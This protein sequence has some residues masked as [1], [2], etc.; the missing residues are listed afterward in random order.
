MRRFIVRLLNV[1]RGERAEEE[2]S[3]ELTSHLALLEDEHVRRGLSPE[4][5]RQA[6]RRA[7][8]SVALTQERHRD[9]R[10]FVWLDDAWRDLR[11]A[12]R[13]LVRSPGFALVTILTMALSIGATT[14]LFSL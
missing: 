13:M 2:L 4:D 3:R 7:M 8:G 10:S 11:F 14:T 12:M 5:A 6:A 9:A 1:F